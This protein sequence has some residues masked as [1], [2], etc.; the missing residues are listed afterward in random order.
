M[1]DTL[2]CIICDK[3]LESAIP[4][5]DNHNQPY[6]GTAFIASGHYGST[7]WDPN[8]SM[9]LGAIPRYLE[10]N[11]CD[12]CIRTKAKEEKYILFVQPQ[13]VPRPAPIVEFFDAEKDY[14]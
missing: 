7:V 4:E 9:V 5:H 14:G 8:D 11:I 2:P 3:A 6:A 12:D 1:T 10:I 13:Y